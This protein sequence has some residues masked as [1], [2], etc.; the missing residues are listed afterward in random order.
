MKKL[1]LPFAGILLLAAFPLSLNAQEDQ[2]YF[3]RIMDADSNPYTFHSI[4]QRTPDDFVCGYEANDTWGENWYSMCLIKNKRKYQLQLIVGHDAQI[5]KVNKRLAHRLEESV[6]NRMADAQRI[7]EEDDCTIYDIAE[8]LDCFKLYVIQ[9]TQIAEYWSDVSMLI[10]EKIWRDEYFKFSIA[11]PNPVIKNKRPEPDED[12]VI[13]IPEVFPEFPGG[14]KALSDYL[15]ENIKYPT[16]CQ[17]DSIQGRVIVTFIVDKEGNIANAEVVK[18]V[19]EQLNA[20]A[21]RVI[22]AMPKWKP[23]KQ[24][25][26]V[27]PVRYSLPVNFRLDGSGYLPISNK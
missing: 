21:L 23:G 4:L 24:R 17:R 12:E 14:M 27:V 11:I 5:R 20:E 18:G 8:M 16:D 9:P 3:E 26:Y 10:P 22:K 6:V 2:Y 1:S 7:Q 13:M 25:G 19:H 15:D